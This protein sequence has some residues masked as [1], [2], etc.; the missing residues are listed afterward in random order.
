[1]AKRRGR[2]PKTTEPTEPPKPSTPEFLVFNKPDIGID[3]IEA[4]TDVLRS[5]WLSTGP[6]AAEFEKEFGAF[7]GEGYP[8]ALASC[9]HGLMLA[10]IV[11]NVGDGKEVICPSMT[12][13]ATVNAILA[14]GAKPVFVEVLPSGHIDPEQIEMAITDRTRAIIPV[15][16][17]GAACNMKRIMEIAQKRGLT[18]IEDA[19][20]AFDGWYVEPMVGDQPGLRRQIGTIGDFTSFSFYATKNITCGEGGLLMCKR[21]DLA[22]RVRVLSMQGLSAGS[23]RRYSADPI[24]AYEVSLTGHKANLS[25]IHAAL[26]LAQLKRWPEMKARR[27]AVWKVYEDAFGL[28]EPGHAKH[29]FTIRHKQRDALRRFL[30]GRGIGTGVHFRAL[31]LEPAYKPLGYSIGQFPMAERIGNETVS[32]PVSNCMTEEDAL[33]VVAA[34]KEFGETK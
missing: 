19:A 25:D 27:E 4:V 9:T 1:M 6:K 10:L 29:L 18:V 7:I 12:Y 15:H 8:V 34:V 13:C 2:P 23:Y 3:E 32:L 31:H 30:H 33:R 16:Y 21:P 11:S 20:H 26:G 28:R 17:T 14:V 5:G 24:M 22:E